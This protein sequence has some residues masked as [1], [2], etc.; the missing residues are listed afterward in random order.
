MTSDTE[1]NRVDY[2]IIIYLSGPML[3]Y[4]ILHYKKGIFQPLLQFQ[5]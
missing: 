3:Y 5:S 4:F 1:Y 2:I